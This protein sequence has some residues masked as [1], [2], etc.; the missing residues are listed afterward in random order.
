MKPAYIGQKKEHYKS[1]KAGK[2][3]LYA[4]VT[5]LT[6]GLGAVSVETTAQADTTPEADAS[7]LVQTN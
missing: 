6:L 5:V 2:H 4:C 1:Y 7:E 3:W